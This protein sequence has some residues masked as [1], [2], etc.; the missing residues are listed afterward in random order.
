MRTFNKLILTT[1]A[2]A[3][4]LTP[5]AH[6]DSLITSAPGAR[7]LVG[8]GGYLAWSVPTAD[9][10][11][12]LAIRSPAGA[13]SQPSIPAFE[14][15]A[16]P[17]IGSNAIYGPQRKLVAV[18]ARAG[19]VYE[20]DLK[21]GTESKLTKLSSGGNET[22]AAINL[23]QY[24]VARQGK[25]LFVVS[26]SGRTRRLASTVPAEIAVAQSRVA[27][28]ESSGYGRNRAVVRRLSGQGKTLSLG[29]GLKGASSLWL[30]RYRAGYA[31]SDAQDGTRL[32]ATQRF[33][34]SGGPFTLRV[35]RAG[36]TSNSALHGIAIADGE[37]A[38][39]LDD[40]GVKRF[41]PRPFHG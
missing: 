16:Q 10:H 33:A 23:G 12:R 35:S 13:V 9:G 22:L 25:G 31:T 27:S 32:Y 2:L 21:T 8:A 1:V 17:S 5:V 11:W 41:D 15:P 18:Y 39:Y 40:Q 24:V 38:F 14:R 6:A 19:D 7:N 4:T 29:T 26:R 37:P 20:L 28:I 34:G 36:W 30:T 3:A